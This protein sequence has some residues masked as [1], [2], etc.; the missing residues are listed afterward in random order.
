MAL[1]LVQLHQEGMVCDNIGV[2]RVRVLINAKVRLSYFK[3]FLIFAYVLPLCA[4]AESIFTLLPY[5]SLFSFQLFFLNSEK[6]KCRL[7]KHSY[8]YLEV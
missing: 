7:K 2:D 4:C 1:S 6:Y 8:N 3:Q 5:Y